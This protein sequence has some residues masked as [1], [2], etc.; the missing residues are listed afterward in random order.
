M[1][2][3]TLAATAGAEQHAMKANGQ[4][5]RWI[6]AAR[7]S[8]VTK[9]NR[10]RGDSLINGIQT[11]D[12]AAAEWAQTEGHEIVAVTKDR[13]VSGVIPPSQRP[14]LGPWLTEPDKLV[15]YD[16]IVAHAVDRLSRRYQD[17]TWLRD[18]A[19]RN[20]K[21]LY[22]IKD[23]LRWPD[24]HDGTLWAVTA[25]RADQE[26]RDIAE[27]IARENDA[28]RA[29]GKFVGRP[30]FGYAVK[31]EKY[32]KRLVP[33]REG[34]KYVPLIYQHMIDGWS[35]NQIAQWL[36]DEGAK[37]VSG[38]WWTR[39]IGLLIKN[40]VYMGHYSARAFIPADETEDVDGKTIRWRYGNSWVLYPRWEYGKTLHE[41][42]P[43]VDAATWQQANE[44]LSEVRPKRSRYA[45][46]NRAMLAGALYC[47]ECEDSPMYRHHSPSPRKGR[48]RVPMFYYRCRNRGQR[49][50]CGLMLRVEVADNAVNEIM[51]R[52]YDVPIIVMVHKP[53]NE[54][55]IERALAAV[56]FKLRRLASQELPR[57]REQAE[58]E[59]LWAEQD[60]LKAT[61]LTGPTLERDETATA[62]YFEEWERV[63]VPERGPWLAREGFRVTAAR[64]EITVVHAATG[65]KAALPL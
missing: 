65:I 27:R 53:G 26:R 34:K 45:A 41:C 59:R 32:D 25:E 4:P 46:E 18:W 2:I 44:A 22:V 50:S 40:P 33:T 60:Q 51:R 31:G 7:L 21:K 20:G 8:R 12:L 61:P 42:K 36:R 19:E 17:V 3:T 6:V 54:L 35:Q 13:N 16:G 37:P 56:D 15:Q 63:P 5:E 14:E 23:R 48:A 62:T 1:T 11:Q 49:T 57:E 24:Q 64:N 47:A 58:R 39:T 9:Q 28:L 43:L 30:P 55:A 52:K 10:E 38:V 29:A